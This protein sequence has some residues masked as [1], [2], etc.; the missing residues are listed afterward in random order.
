MLADAIAQNKAQF[1]KGL[2]KKAEDAC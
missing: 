2:S 1:R